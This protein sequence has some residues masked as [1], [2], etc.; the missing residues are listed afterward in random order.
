MKKLLFVLSLSVLAIMAD[1]QVPGFCI[2]PKIGYNSN[3][4]SLDK[5]GISAGLKS[6]FQ[7][8]AF[9]RLGKK[10][11]LQPEANYQIRGGILNDDRATS[12]SSGEQTIKLKTISVP[13]L[14]GF[15]VI[16]SGPFNLRL[17]AGPTMSFVIDKELKPAEMVGVWPIHSKDD[18]KNSIWSLQAGGGIDLFSFTL[19]VRYE[20][21]LDNMY[22]GTDD[23]NLKNNIFNVSLG[24]KLL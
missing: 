4:L 18:I 7:F 16:N 9:M 17:M 21:G 22:Q 12:S 10:V 13:V 20:I 2:G 14:L 24:F 19:D 11:Y 1:A 15:R 8:G 6:E 5:E 23:F 3:A